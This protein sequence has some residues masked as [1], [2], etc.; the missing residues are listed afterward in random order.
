MK[1]LRMICELYT[2][3][4]LGY[5]NLT[6]KKYYTLFYDKIESVFHINI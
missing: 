2:N 5:F 3:R 4:Y 6:Y 1:G